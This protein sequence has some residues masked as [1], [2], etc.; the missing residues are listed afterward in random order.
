[1]SRRWPFR[2]RKDHGNLRRVRVSVRSLPKT[3]VPR[4]VGRVSTPL[5]GSTSLWLS[6][7][8]GRRRVLSDWNGFCVPRGLS[9]L[10][11]GRLRRTSCVEKRERPSDPSLARSWRLAAWPRYAFPHNPRQARY[12]SSGTARLLHENFFLSRPNSPYQV[13]FSRTQLA[14][15]QGRHPSPETC[16]AAL[17]PQPGSP[18][19]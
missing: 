3:S 11:E 9:R 5:R 18:L 16:G 12:A 2:W 4:F 1:V 7:R 17:Q 10:S 8:P 19:R 6:W 13:A 15:G 14:D